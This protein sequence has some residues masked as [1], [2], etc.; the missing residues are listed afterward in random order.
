MGEGKE[1]KVTMVGQGGLRGEHR[2][3]TRPKAT[4]K[5]QTQTTIL[6]SLF[7][8]TCISLEQKKAVWT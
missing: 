8:L 3:T 5:C 4:A 2:K 7:Y 6:N 1:G